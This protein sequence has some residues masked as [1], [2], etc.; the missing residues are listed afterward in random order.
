M[1]MRH[2]F[3]TLALLL[4]LAPALSIATP[5]LAA[6]CLGRTVTIAGAGTI[7]G[8]TG[9]D[10]ILGSSRNDT[11]HGNGGVDKICGLDGKDAIILDTGRV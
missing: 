2:I 8:T 11:I 9:N 6:S 1:V 5:A 7:N 10:V 3:R 4:L